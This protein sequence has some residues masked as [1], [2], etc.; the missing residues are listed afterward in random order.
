VHKSIILL[1]TGE[2]KGMAQKRL[3]TTGDAARVL[4]RAKGRR[5]SRAAV[6]RLAEAGELRLFETVSGF[7][8][9]LSEDVERLAREWV[10]QRK[11]A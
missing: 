6:L 3:M 5:V 8:V 10:F 9:L 7:R 11:T 1:T 2:V 4:S